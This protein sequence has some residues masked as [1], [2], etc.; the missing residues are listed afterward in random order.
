MGAWWFFTGAWHLTSLSSFI[1]K[2]AVNN[3]LAVDTVTF[4]INY[5]LVRRGSQLSTSPSGGSFTVVGGGSVRSRVS[6]RIV[7]SICQILPPQRRTTTP[8]AVTFSAAFPSAGDGTRRGASTLLNVNAKDF[9]EFIA[10]AFFFVK[11]KHSLRLTVMQS[12]DLTFDPS[13]KRR[14]NAM[15]AM[16]SFS[17]IKSA[18]APNIAC[19]HSFPEL[20]SL[21]LFL[22]DFSFLWLT[23]VSRIH[24]NDNGLDF[25]HTFQG[26]LSTSHWNHYSFTPHWWW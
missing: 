21:L 11:P 25:Y 5:C 19:L 18:R 1:I 14:E 24:N 26:N 7:N 23:L 8:G 6:R 20:I 3:H 10:L 2:E 13:E 15:T 22:T 4:C 16:R 9:D 12:A 17:M